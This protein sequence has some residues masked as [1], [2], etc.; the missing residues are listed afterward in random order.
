MARIK[1]CPKCGADI[2]DSYLSED[3]ECGIAGGWACEVCN[4]GIADEEPD[5][6]DDR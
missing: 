1:E 2:S 4:I 5:D 3:P 6:Y